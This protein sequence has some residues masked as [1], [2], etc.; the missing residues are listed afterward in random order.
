M[1]DC[2]EGECGSHHQR[3]YVVTSPEFHSSFYLTSLVSHASHKV[4]LSFIS[5]PPFSPLKYPIKYS[6]THLR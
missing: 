1:L 3:L 5:F 2:W 6:P 4:I